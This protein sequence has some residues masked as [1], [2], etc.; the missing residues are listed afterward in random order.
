M[1]S[2]KNEMMQKQ[3]LYL[4]QHWTPNLYPEISLH[5]LEAAFSI[6]PIFTWLRNMFGN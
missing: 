2:G 3:T 5:T 6:A 4:P 1:G